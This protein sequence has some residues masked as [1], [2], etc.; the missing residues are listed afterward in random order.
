L[1][2]LPALKELD[3]SAAKGFAY[4][5]GNRWCNRLE[6]L[7]AFKEFVYSYPAFQAA[8]RF[9]PFGIEISFSGV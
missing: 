8:S 4:L 1:A 3:L 9:V 6:D 5:G 7:S 2:D